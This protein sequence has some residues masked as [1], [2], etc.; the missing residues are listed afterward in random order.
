VPAC[1]EKDR[2]HAG[3]FADRPLHV[4]LAASH[5]SATA[6]H[7]DPMRE[8]EAYVRALRAPL[9]VQHG[10]REIVRSATL[11][12]NAHNAQAWKFRLSARSIEVLPDRTRRT[13]VVDPDDHHLFASLGCAVENL[14]LAAAALGRPSQVHFD[15]E[16]GGKLLVDVRHGPERSSALFSAIAHRQSTRTAFDGRTIDATDRAQLASAAQVPGVEVILITDK[17]AVE[18][19]LELIV[20]ATSL[21]M[22]DAAF[23][24]EL[25]QWMR[26]NPRAALASGDG[27]FTAATGNR[28]AP[29]WAGRWLFDLS[30]RVKSE[31]AKHVRHVRSSAGL[32]IFAAASNDPEHWVQAGRSC[33]RFALQ[34]TALGI[35]HAFVNQAV[36]VPSVRS[37]L[38]NLLGLTGRRPDLVMRF[39][40]GKQLPLSARRPLGNVVI[41]ST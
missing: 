27:L 23:L 1:P 11:A 8:Y 26:F 40:Y 31:C 33:Q 18:Q 14:T 39:G 32:A 19:V 38:A 28:T 13:P 35:R 25:K 34:A 36:E 22:R 16:G 9:G 24:R 12:A 17:A 4:T 30:F 15:Y 3:S 10:M 41:D 37:E 21:Q 7:I 29:T 2:A 20:A 6:E 5:V